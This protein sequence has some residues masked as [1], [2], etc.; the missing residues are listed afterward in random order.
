MDS[1][2]NLVSQIQKLKQNTSFFNIGKTKL[3]Q[4]I[5]CFKIGKPTGY[6]ILLQAGI[7]A[8]EYITCFLLIKIINFLKNFEIDA[9]IFV[10][11][12]A[13]PDG[14][15]ICLDGT[16]FLSKAQKQKFLQ[17]TNLK[18]TQILK[19][20]FNGVDL[21]TNFN[22]MWGKGLHNE[23]E[24]NYQNFVGYLPNSESE[25]KTF[26]NFLNVFKPDLTL[27][28]HS[29]GEVVYWGFDKR[30]DNS[31]NFLKQEKIFLKTIKKAT[32]YKLAKTKNSCGG[33]KDYCL[34][35]LGTQ[36]FTIEVGSDTLSHPIH[37][38]NLKSIFDKNKFLVLNLINA[39]KQY[40]IRKN[41]AN[42]YRT[43]KNCL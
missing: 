25:T 20:N 24:P 17:N 23:F 26:V 29:K 7:H 41:N 4:N 36:G 31:K 43:G 37:T 12:I 21:N 34:C 14:V 6:K 3:N 10:V 18:N 9:Q 16:K 19:S 27:C 22:A 5:V 38:T 13:N 11:P 15:K 2:K 30:K 28:F 42:G 32:K 35:K 40:F 8:R 33:L 39:R 1:Y